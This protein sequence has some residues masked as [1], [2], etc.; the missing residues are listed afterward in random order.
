MYSSNLMSD[1]GLPT[2]S[3]LLKAGQGAEPAL[4]KR[5][6]LRKLWSEALEAMDELLEVV[7]SKVSKTDARKTGLESGDRLMEEP[8][9][10][11]WNFRKSVDVSD[12]GLGRLAKRSDD[13]RSMRVTRDGA[14]IE[15][16]DGRVERMAKRRTWGVITNPSS[17]RSATSA[18]A[19]DMSDTGL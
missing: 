14:V 8:V 1:T 15:Y 16:T 17:E 11:D 12:S 18:G 4:S 13:V 7:S 19:V 2:G 6:E 5:E 10:G 3:Q 9:F